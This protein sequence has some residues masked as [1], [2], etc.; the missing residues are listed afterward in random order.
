MDS[1][2]E[3]ELEEEMFEKSEVIELSSGSKSKS[4][5]TSKVN[6]SPTECAEFV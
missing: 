2:L 5:E 4:A 6:M 3:D 1:F